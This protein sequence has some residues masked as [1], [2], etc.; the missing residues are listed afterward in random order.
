MKKH[1]FTF[2]LLALLTT[3]AF[4]Q[5]PDEIASEILEKSEITGGFVVHLGS[6]DGKV[7]AALRANESILVHGLEPD[8]AKV[9][10]A[11]EAIRKA[12]IYGPVSIEEFSGD[13]LPYL[14]ELANLVV[15]EDAGNVA[16]EEILRV[17]RPGGVLLKKDGDD[18]NKTV[19]EWPEDIDD[20]SHFFHNA[21]GNAVAKDDKVGPPRHMRWVGSPRWSRHHDRMASM[22]ALV[23]NEG[24]L[25]YIMD[26][27][28]RI[29]IQLPPKWKVVARD[30]FNGVV[31]WKRDIP[32]WHSHLWP[33]KSGPTQL[34]RRLVATG[35]HVYVTLGIAAPV[36]QIDAVTGKTVRE[37]AGS[38]GAEELIV[39]GDTLYL[40]AMDGAH[41][42]SDY[43]PENG[44]TGDQTI[45]RQ[46][47]KWNELPRKMQA[48]S[49]KTGEKLWE[50]V[51]VVSPL[52]LAASESRAF[53]HDG[54][55]V[56]ARDGKTGDE[57]WTGPRADRV[58]SMT[59]NFGPKMVVV[60]D[61]VLFAGGDRKMHT[62][63]A[64]SGEQLWEAPHARGGYQS[65]EDLLVLKNTVWS[66]P[67][68]SG[69]DSGTFTGRDLMTGDVVKE[70]SPNVETYWF[71]HRCYIAK[72]TENFLM[73]SRTGIEFV[74]PQSEHWDINH[75]V[76]GGCLYGVMPANGLTYAP[77]HN[78]ACY[79]ET[80][81]YGFNALS[82]AGPRP[83]E[84]TK[85]RLA[86]GP[87]F[88]KIDAAPIAETD[89]P[90]FRGDGQR[91]GFTKEKIG[92]ENLSTVWENE[93]GGKLTAL[94]SANGKV[95]VSQIEQH[96]VHALD[97]ES[98]EIAWSFTTGG[99]VDSP[100]TIH[101]GSVIF[102]CADGHVYCL[103]ATDGKLAWKFQAAPSS[104]RHMAFEQLESVW[105][106]HGSVLVKDGNALFVA[107]RS[108]F[109]DGGLRYYNLNVKTGEVNSEKIIN[110]IN[111]ETGNNLQEKIATLQMPSGLP[112]IL[113]ASNG[114]IYMRSQK[115][116]ETG[117]RLEIGPHS[118]DAATQGAV[119]KDGEHLFA[120]MSFLDDTW[121]HRSYWVFGKSFAGGHNGYYQA[122]K[123]TPSGRIL[124]FDS[125]N[126]YGFGRKPEYLKW[127]TTLEHQLFS[128]SRNAPEGALSAVED[129]DTRRGK[130]KG[131]GQGAQVG[132]MIDFGV[133]K[134]LDPSLKPLAVGAWVKP[135]NKEGAIAVHGGPAIGYGL[136]MRKGVPRFLYRS[137]EEK[138]FAAVAKEAIPMGE[139][140]HLFGQIT[141]DKK[142]EL[143]VNGKLVGTGKSDAFIT[144]SPAQGLQ[145]GTDDG[146]A[147]GAYKSKLPFKGVID[148]VF[149]FHGTATAEEVAARF[150]NPTDAPLPE[151]TSPVVIADFNKGDASDQSGNTNTGRLIGVKKIAEGKVGGAFEFSG[152]AGGYTGGKQGGT[153]VKH[154]WTKEVPLLAR[155]MV[156]A[157]RTIFVAGPRDLFNENETWKQIAEDDPKVQK[158][159]AEQDALM[160]GNE[161]V[162]RAVS[163][164]TGET[165]TEIKIDALPRWDG[166]AAAG[167]KLFMSTKDGRVIAIAGE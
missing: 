94:V 41:E 1:G 29:S 113:C 154:H 130:G 137:S 163:A 25:F 11:R 45:V 68:T 124:V 91:S 61:K 32:E 131:K 30:A 80:K 55:K 9:K 26:E 118:G 86:E 38:D 165:I 148:E 22:S 39:D 52:T 110:E 98:G 74:D 101:D 46:R 43:V 128:A 142:L 93:L 146:T 21:G 31:L 75:W 116:D 72:A 112:D 138:L 99:R 90:T 62:Y 60:G 97:A 87:A 64:A 120:P 135:T 133:T 53:Y 14:E 132:S 77:P 8:A 83:D 164:D 42:L 24:R 96:T 5:S 27:G 56:V 47:W 126:V 4:S 122:G 10:S 152:K 44:G 157:D 19:K 81:L 144:K 34:A 69:R 58:Q 51:S 127:T 161:G 159:L 85:N 36:S 162:L 40:M 155:A 160:E 88:G 134:T 3:P 23:S 104:E 119:Q 150:K 57:L 109:L 79:P 102:G 73:P 166:M 158:I 141:A 37:F 114:Y 67:L 18:W 167:G 35:D 151:N 140:T 149:V 147:L 136:T 2:C 7:T 89:W 123:N 106:V 84:P 78:C 115:M 15:V 54:E 17:L 107:G 33:L 103:R 125:E 95:F 59:F 76:R 48:Y 82:A 63:D 111:P 71:H 153:L 139:W 49:T 100:P 65:P 66:A 108:N 156:L 92:T 121:F 143:Y 28:S 13:R 16:E 6:D 20:W 145:V 129:K 117:E 12:G 70:F 105:P 50:H